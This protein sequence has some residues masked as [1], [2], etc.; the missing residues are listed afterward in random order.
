MA[1]AERVVEVPGGIAGMRNEPPSGEA[2]QIGRSDPLDG[3]DRAGPPWPSSD[4]VED[5]RALSV[6]ANRLIVVWAMDRGLFHEVTRS[7]PE[8]RYV[9]LAEA[10]AE[11]NVTY[12]WFADN[13]SAYLAGAAAALKSGTGTIGFVGG[14]DTQ[15]VWKSQ[16]GFEAGARA[17]DRDIEILSD[18]LSAPPDWSGFA[19]P[20]AARRAAEAMYRQ[21]ADIIL[22]AAGISGVGVFEAASDQSRSLG[23]QLWAIGSD[24]DQHETIGRLPGVVEANRWRRHILTSVVNR[25]DQAIYTVLADHAKASLQPGIRSLDLASGY[26]D[27]SYSGGFLDDI[28]TPLEEIRSQIATGQIAIPCLPADRQDDAVAHDVSPSCGRVMPLERP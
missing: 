2:D 8:T 21:G 16:A 27:I 1:G 11:P 23:T 20:A 14:V 25:F 15:V 10:G 26:T 13:E 24:A 19:S 6:D 5:L 9:I 3:A 7:F 22:H 18:Y 17:I 28:R 4:G 12:L